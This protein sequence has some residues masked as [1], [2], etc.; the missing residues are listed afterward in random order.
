MPDNQD[1]ANKVFRES[2]WAS[3]RDALLVCSI[4]DEGLDL[5]DVNEGWL[6]KHDFP[7]CGQ[8][9]TQVRDAAVCGSPICDSSSETRRISSAT[10][11]LELDISI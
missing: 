6:L 4:R 2:N 1:E 7:P 11:S 8:V 3:N 10:F 5:K 9:L